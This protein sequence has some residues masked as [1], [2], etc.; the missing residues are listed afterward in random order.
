VSVL[1]AAQKKGCTIGQIQ[2]ATGASRATAYRDLELL[3][4]SGYTLNTAT[5]NGEAHYFLSASELSLQP[6]TPKERA[7][8]ALAKRALH[9]VDG[10]WLSQELEGVPARAERVVLKG[11]VP[12]SARGMAGQ[13]GAGRRAELGTG[14]AEKL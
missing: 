13:T 14:Q 10:T 5:V 7:A 12:V 11:F 4:E 3:R 9:A 8:I 1:G 2:R 6:M